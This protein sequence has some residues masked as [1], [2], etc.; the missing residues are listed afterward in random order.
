MSTASTPSA[1]PAR[2]TPPTLPAD[3]Y[4][5]DTTPGSGGCMAPPANWNGTPDDYLVALRSRFT[6]DPEARGRMLLAMLRIDPNPARS[7][8]QFRGWLAETARRV[9][10]AGAANLNATRH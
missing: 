9:L 5:I 8:V 3:V 2:P 7:P 6:R 10:L 1:T 4:V